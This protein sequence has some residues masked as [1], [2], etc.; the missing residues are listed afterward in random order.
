MQISKNEIQAAEH[1]QDDVVHVSNWLVRFD[2]ALQS[3]SR[4][5][6]ESLFVADSHWRDLI[7]LTWTVT[8]SDGRSAVVGKFLESQ[9]ISKARGFKLD[10]VNPM[11]RRVTRAGEEVIESFFQFETATGRGRGLVR[12]RVA[13]PNAAWVISTSLR[14]LK[15]FEWQTGRKRADGAAKRIFGGRSWAELRAREQRYDDREPA[16]L[17]VGA[18]HNGLAL[19]A[20]L[21][22]LGV[23]TLIVERLPNVGDVWRNRYSAL[24]LHNETDLNHL[25]YMPFPE[26]WPRYLPKDMLGDWLESYA[27]A[28]ECNV[29]TN[30]TFIGGEFDEDQGVWNARVRTADGAQRDVHPRHLVFANG[31]V[32][33]PKMPDTPGLSDFKGELLHAHGFKSGAAWKGRKAIILGVGNSA[34]D[35]A[36]DLHGHGA[37][38]KMIQRGSITV[39]SLKSA[40]INYSVY[41]NEGLSLDDCDLIVSTNTFPVLLR[42]YQLVTKRAQEIDAKLHEG[43]RARGFKLDAGPENGGHQMKVR[44]SHGGYY[45][46]VGCSDLIVSGDI[47]VIQYEDVERFVPNGVMLKNGQ[48]EEADV[49]VTA[50]GYHSP[51]DVIRDLLGRTIADKIGPVW[52]M[53]EGGEMSNMYKPTAQKGLWFTGHGFSQGRVWSHY[54]A[55]QIKAREEGLVS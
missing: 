29:W 27:K 43:L 4:A 18:G 40:S 2:I 25:P 36:Q 26:N 5:E 11:P 48:I 30:T 49:V 1:S 54:V 16:V 15:G 31:I 14:E 8:P 34:H 9:P 3:G 33:E 46:N 6:L 47:G 20:R 37:T 19:A 22:L 41:Y 45:I 53:D 17:I 10:P 51:T 13:E 23:D 52:G 12:F 39:L 44:Q 21:R 38:V 32:G 28:M 7:A 42:G 35:I 50:T 24:A 55:L